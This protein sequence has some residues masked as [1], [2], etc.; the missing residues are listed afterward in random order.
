MTCDDV[1]GVEELKR[2]RWKDGGVAEL[3]MPI[4]TLSVAVQG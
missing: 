1:E 2:V 3:K 4:I